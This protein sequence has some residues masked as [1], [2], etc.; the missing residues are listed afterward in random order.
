M[1]FCVPSYNLIYCFL[2][3]K[4]F[5]EDRQSSLKL[6]LKDDVAGR[7]GA[8]KSDQSMS[9]TM[10][11]PIQVI[12]MHVNANNISKVICAFVFNVIPF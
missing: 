7:F 2:E 10:K 12:G 1:I 9:S 11:T 3:Q 4:L 6:T 5:I 8:A